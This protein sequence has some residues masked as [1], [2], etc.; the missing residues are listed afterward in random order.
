MVKRLRSVGKYTNQMNVQGGVVVVA[1]RHS[2]RHRESN[3]IQVILPDGQKKHIAG[4]I[5]KPHTN[6]NGYLDGPGNVAL[7]KPYFSLLEIQPDG[8]LIVGDMHSH[9]RIVEAHMPPAIID[10]NDW[11][12]KATPAPTGEPTGKPTPAPTDDPTGKPTS[13]PTDD[14]TGKPTPAPTDDPTGKPTPAPRAENRA[15]HGE[16]GADP[17]KYYLA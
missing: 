5:R 13:A 2:R 11:R 10:K 17:A 3:I 12:F 1:A 14:P 7:F 6:P 9:L 4:K 15:V 16:L 8:N